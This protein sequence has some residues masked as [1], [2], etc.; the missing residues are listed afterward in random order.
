MLRNIPVAGKAVARYRKD[1]PNDL[2][3]RYFEAYYHIFDG[4]PEAGLELAQWLLEVLPEE[5]TK[6]SRGQ[7]RAG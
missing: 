1:Y 6:S 5:L 4:R 3:W 2:K 7:L